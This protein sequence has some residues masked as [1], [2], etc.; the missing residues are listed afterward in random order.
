MGKVTRTKHGLNDRTGV[1]CVSSLGSG[2]GKEA[3]GI[4]VETVELVVMTEARED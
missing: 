2:D 3:E 4:G 1:E